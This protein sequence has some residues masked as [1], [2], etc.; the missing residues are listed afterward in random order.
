MYESLTTSQ[1][2]EFIAQSNSSS[3]PE[4]VLDI[5]RISVLDYLGV[6]LVGSREPLGQI[7][8]Q[9][10]KEAGGQP[11]AG[12]IGGGFKTSVAQ[13]AWVNGTT[14]HAIDYDDYSM[15]WQTHPSVV[16]LPAILALGEKCHIPGRELLTSYAVGFEVGTR[17]YLR[18]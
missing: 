7:I 5:I 12:I 10:V 4:Q 9:Y 18:V 1:I 6:A 14:S 2:V 8:T 11:E 3:I 17:V 16:I 15:A 13:A